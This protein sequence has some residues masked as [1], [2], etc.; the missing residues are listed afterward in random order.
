MT[1]FVKQRGVP[2]PGSIPAALDIF[3]SEIRFYREIAPVIGVRVPACYR[4]ET[5]ADGTVLVLEDLSAWTPGA[6]PM[7]AARTL[8]RMHHQWAGQ[9]AA[10]W[11]WLRPVGAAVELVEDLYARTWP[12]LAQ[13]SD[14][15]GGVRRLAGQLVGQVTASE[16]ATAA[17]GPLTLVHGDASAANMRTSPSGEVALLDWED[18]SAAAGVGDLAWFLVSSVEPGDWDATIDAYG[19]GRP[20]NCPARGR[21]ARPAHPC[22]LRGR[23]AGS[24]RLDR[25]ARL[26]S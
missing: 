18:V 14:L 22:R 21:G 23:F 2:A 6:D 10:R 24:G 19:S 11:P 9:A 15:P 1:E 3:R 26:R 16:Y 13:R 8:A 20:G 12:A 5:G 4:A 7:A 25:P 17:A